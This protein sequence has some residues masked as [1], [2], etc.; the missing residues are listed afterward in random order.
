M[1]FIYC[2]H[3]FV[4]QA[5]LNILPFFMMDVY[6][7]N[8][9]HIGNT[10]HHPFFLLLWS[11]S[12]AVGLYVY[13]ILIWKKYKISYSKGLHFLICTGWIFSCI[14]PYSYDLPGWINDA[15]VWIAVASTV[16]FGL[17]WIY[18]HTKKE[19]FIYSEIK[20]LLYFLDCV[21]ILCIFILALA[22]HVNG[23][24]EILFSFGI[25]VILVSF[26]LR[27]VL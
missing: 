11:A 19:S 17:E 8:M 13:S 27:Y 9:T 22:G 21:F 4:L 16:G 15:H 14:I 1:K 10:L 18:I 5:I 25:N 24:C 23:L 6:Y 26:L 3:A 2:I 7:D 12:C 20:T